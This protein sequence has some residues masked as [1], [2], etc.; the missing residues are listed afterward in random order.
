[1]TQKTKSKKQSLAYQGEILFGVHPVHLA[2]L[3]KKRTFYHLYTREDL[4]SNAENT[5]E[6]GEI[7]KLAR[8]LNVPISFI[9]SKGLRILAP[10]AVHQVIFILL[11][12]FYCLAFKRTLFLFCFSTLIVRS[13][14]QHAQLFV[15]KNC[16]SQSS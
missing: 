15:L 8:I 12:C 9:D 16:A 14:V 4:V 10:G 11:L 13:C 1:M 3:Q 7:I 5:S 6:K 2:L